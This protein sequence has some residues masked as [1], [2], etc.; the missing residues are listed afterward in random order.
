MRDAENME[1]IASNQETLT[2][3]NF[4]VPQHLS[5]GTITRHF[6][7]E[8]SGSLAEMADSP[9]LASWKPTELS[10]FQSRTRYAPGCTKSE[11]RQGNLSQA[12]L[13]GMKLKGVESNFPTPIGM[14]IS[15]CKGNFYTGNGSRYSYIVG[16]NQSSFDLDKIVATTNPYVNS[17]YLR[18]YPGM[19][20]ENLRTNGIM[21]V[22]NEN[23]VF[24]DYQHP[25]VEMMAENQDTLQLD[26]KN[27]KLIDNRWY[28]VSKAVTD[29]CLAELGEELDSNLPLLDFT[30]FQVC[31]ERLN[32]EAWDAENIVCDNMSNEQMRN[33]VLDATRRLHA[34]VEITYSFM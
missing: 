12:I 5:S 20:S 25:I 31:I 24:V 10:V 33:K 16:S 21:A 3:N 23:Y 1:T 30:K 22:P 15:G 7:V 32:G 14:T 26:L 4:S 18:L 9:S 19:T 11:F 6:A 17:E 13:I 8:F 34:V 29:R 28:K 27:A 2:D